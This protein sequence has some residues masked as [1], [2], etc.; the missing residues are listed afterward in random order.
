MVPRRYLV[1][2][3]RVET[4][5]PVGVGIVC[6]HGEVSLA[7]IEIG[8]D[9]DRFYGAGGEMADAARHRPGVKPH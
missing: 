5:L 8:R 6:P 7:A 3:I 2:A 9:L 1:C 4:G